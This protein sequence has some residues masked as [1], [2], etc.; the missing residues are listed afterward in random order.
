M[1]VLLLLIEGALAGSYTLESLLHTAGKHNDLSKALSQEALSLKAKSRA[2][3]ATDP[4]AL[5]VEGTCL[6]GWWKVW[7]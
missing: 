5:Y 3:T 7:K 1:L 6:S 4:I 2:D